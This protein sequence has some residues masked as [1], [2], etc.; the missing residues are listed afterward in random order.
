MAMPEAAEIPE[1]VCTVALYALSENA[2]KLSPRAG[3][4]DTGGMGTSSGRQRTSIGVLFW[5]AF[6]LLVLVIFLANRSNIEQVLESTGIVDVVRDRLEPDERPD[7]VER[8]APADEAPTRDV[9]VV[10]GDDEPAPVRRPAPT[11]RDPLAPSGSSEPTT[12]PAPATQPAREPEPAPA[13]EPSASDDR[14]AVEPAAPAPR[15]TA[16][17]QREPSPDPAKPNRLMAGLY[18]IRVTD[19]GRTFPQRVV[20]PVYYASSP[21]TETI[22]SLIDGPSGDELD[23]G[24]LNLIPDGT[25]LISAHVSGGVAYLNFNESFR[26]NPLGAEGTV[27]Q[28]L[29]VIYSSTEFST[30]ERVQFMVEGEELDYL[31]GDGIY[32][33]EPLG[34]DAFSS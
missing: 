19:D 29:Q 11:S 32:V 15:T 1:S 33:G 6:I 17:A 24:L 5:I 25:E 3:R 9:P 22:R 30:V 16:P 28:L 20:R 21:L 7:A 26:F 34:R 23:D 8:P 2:V 4:A 14:V 12:R 13:R 10:V 18:F 31:G 27:A